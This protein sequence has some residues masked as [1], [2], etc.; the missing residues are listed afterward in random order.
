MLPQR[1]V[2]LGG[3]FA[4]DGAVGRRSDSVAAEPLEALNIRSRTAGSI[5]AVIFEQSSKEFHAA[6][7][8]RLPY[9]ADAQ[10]SVLI[11]IVIRKSN[12]NCVLQH[13]SLDFVQHGRG[14]YQHLVLSCSTLVTEYP[15]GHEVAFRFC[16][17]K[18]GERKTMPRFASQA[19][20]DGIRKLRF[21]RH[22]AAE[23]LARIGPER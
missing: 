14:C 8:R 6:H 1:L 23:I 12:P 15:G 3:N 13:R 17:R 19:T 18:L 22:C 9:N 10:N 20:A 4:A 7:L 2:E 5:E 11:P 16:G 21:P